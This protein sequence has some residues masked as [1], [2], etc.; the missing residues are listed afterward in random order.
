MKR[1]TV[2]AVLALLLFLPS[3]AWSLPP[4]QNPYIYGMHDQPDLNLFS[5]QNSCAKGW[6]TKL[7]YIGHDGKCSGIDETA[8]ANKGY[9]VIMRL[10]HGGS[11]APPADP[12]HFSGYA[13]TF[14][15][16]IKNSKGVSVWIV[17][18]EPN[19]PW[20]HPQ[21]RSFKPSEYGEIY[22]QVIQEV[23][24]LPN[25][26]NHQILFAAM[27]PWASVKPWGD[28]EKGLAKSIDYVKNKGTRID[29]LALHAYTKANYSPSAITSDKKWPGR[30]NWYHH[31]RQYRNYT[32]I[33]KNKNI[34]DIPLYITEAGNAC[35]PPCDPY[36]DK[37]NGYW[38]AMW[39]EINNWNKNNPRQ[40]IRAITPYRWTKNKDGTNRDF[41]IGCSNPLKQDIANAV[42]KNWTWKSG[43][44][45]HNGGSCT[46]KCSGKQCGPDGCG[47]S[48]GHCSGSASC[49]S[50]QCVT[51]AKMD[52][53]TSSKADAWQPPKYDTST[54]T[55]GD[56]DSGAGA[57]SDAPQIGNPPSGS[58]GN[59][60]KTGGSANEAD[61]SSST[62]ASC[63]SGGAG[64][65]LRSPLLLLAAIAA[66]FGRRRS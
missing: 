17:A 42:S 29:A 25:S 51:N 58:N 18:N 13:K 26:Q 47:G 15:E 9:G 14:A 24:K 53:G 52:T 41:C 56:R 38:T 33:L 59:G 8:L 31:F 7:K 36:P 4:G 21:N 63:S 64:H 30:P 49:Q 6:V 61:G 65:P 11:P 60:S 1:S 20:G 27:A 50:G 62:T 39:R 37:N 22:H 35:D 16:C 43:A 34:L 10:D 12:A 40:R 2:L 66:L 28:W 3:V 46:P 19:I 5:G 23:D 44:G 54:S 45:C 48:C 55:G 32:T 57:E